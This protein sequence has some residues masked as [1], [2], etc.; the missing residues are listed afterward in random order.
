[1]TPARPVTPAR[2]ASPAQ[3]ASPAAEVARLRGTFAAGITKPV[4][5]RRDQ[6][7][8]LATLLDTESV[9]LTEAL[10]ADLG[11]S[12]TE[13]Y[14]TEIGFV[15]NEVEH[16]L[17]HLD[18]WLRTSRTSVPAFLR[19]A[20]ARIVREPLG[21][22]M[23]ISPWNYPVQ[24]ALAPL[25]GALAA[26]NCVVVKPSEIAP[27]TSA[28]LARLLPRYLDSDAV[29]VLEGG[30]PET[31]ALLA[32]R[33]DHIFFT[34][35]GTV[36]RVVMTAAAKHLTPVTLE[37]GGK[38][39]AVVEPGPHLAAV[40]RRI[41]WGKFLN[42]GQTCVAPDY[43]LAAGDAGPSLES[44]LATA[45]TAMYGADP[46]MSPDYG[47]IVSAR[48]FDR[49][50]PMLGDGRVVAGGGFERAALYIAPTVLADV[51][52]A[53]SVMREEIFGPRQAARAIRVHIERYVQAAADHPD[54]VR[55]DLFRAARRAS[56]RARAAVRRGGRERDGPLPRRILHRHVQPQQGRARQATAPRHVA[57]GLPAVHPRQAVPAPQAH[58]AV[59]PYLSARSVLGA[60]PVV[61]AGPLESAAAPVRRCAASSFTL[62]TTVTNV[63]DF[64]E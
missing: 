28:T 6:L 4:H 10:H 21:V 3:S 52:P 34:G 25:A 49:L 12:A 17:R 15:A 2:L 31:T 32:Q 18:S 44:H 51:D 20:R 35:N 37:L 1:V 47:R 60:G 45:I 41:A 36:G 62:F 24:L 8:A 56:D 58:L 23:I 11:K 5:W 39:P 57:V 48:Q 22:V 27:H 40:A 54:V 61:C 14:T 13:A 16:V 55:R 7:R 53:A 26:G 43:V 29:A 59:I 42:A 19:P 33:F 63:A 30:V 9:A 46:A 64:A 50:V 38:S